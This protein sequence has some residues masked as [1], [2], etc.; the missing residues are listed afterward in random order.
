MKIKK[1]LAKE[2]VVR[3][4]NS[5]APWNHPE[6]DDGIETPIKELDH[7]VHYEV[8]TIRAESFVVDRKSDVLSITHKWRYKEEEEE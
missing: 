7:M 2:G 8:C 6:V 5:V 4:H 3:L 1:N